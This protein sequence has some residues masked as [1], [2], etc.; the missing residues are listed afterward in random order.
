MSSKCWKCSRI[1]WLGERWQFPPMT[2]GRMHCK[3]TSIWNT[4]VLNIGVFLLLIFIFFVMFQMPTEPFDYLPSW[5]RTLW[6]HFSILFS[7]HTR[8]FPHEAVCGHGFRHETSSKRYINMDDTLFWKNIVIYRSYN[9][10]IEMWAFL[11]AITP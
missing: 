9:W 4:N 8:S 2:T 3:Y 7:S 1:F 6:G 10:K 11:C 5:C